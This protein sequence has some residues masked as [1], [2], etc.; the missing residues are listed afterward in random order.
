MNMEIAKRNPFGGAPRINTPAEFGITDGKAF[1]YRIPVI[2]M[3]PITLTVQTDESGVTFENG[4]LGGRVRGEKEFSI[5]IIAEN[6]LGKAEREMKIVCERHG[7]GRTP[8]LGFTSWNAFGAQVTQENIEKTAADLIKSGIADYGYYY[9]N[10]D[11]GWQEKYGGPYDAIQPNGRFPDMKKMC[12][13][14]HS[15]GLRAGIYS[16]PM[17][18]AWGCPQELSSIP[19]CTQGAPDPRFPN[20]ANGGIGLIHKE[21]NNVKQWEEWGFDYLKYDWAPTDAENA[22][23]MRKELEA[24]GREFCFCVTVSAE[25]AAAKYW[26]ENVNSWR[27]NEDTYP[28]WANTLKRTGTLDVWADYSH[29]GHFYDLDMLVMDDYYSGMRKGGTLTHEE[30]ILEYTMMAFFNSPLQISTPIEQLTEERLD[31]LCNEE[32]IEINQDILGDY[33]RPVRKDGGVM[34]YQRKL[35]DGGKAFAVFNLTG[36]T[37]A[38]EL[39]VGAAKAV[40]DISVRDVWKKQDVIAENGKLSFEVEPHCARVFRVS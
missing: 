8:L 10:L 2:G 31:I 15:Y 25:Y 6:A 14:I 34:V 5:K 26:S 36:E 12:G 35:A 40:R 4:V 1:L 29:T 24:S 23:L 3:R 7:V 22:E 28:S 19:G 38:E 30:E 9:V 13:T 27:C 32:M 16:T 20:T 33:P 18:R 21:K 11:S 39:D 37:V 17:L